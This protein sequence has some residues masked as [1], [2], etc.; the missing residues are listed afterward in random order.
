[1]CIT[2]QLLFY[3]IRNAF[4]EVALE[5]RTPLFSYSAQSIVLNGSFCTVAGL[6]GHPSHIVVSIGFRN[7]LCAVITNG[8]DC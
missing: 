3:I 8:I 1:M 6:V 5:I 2:D 4:I 7:V